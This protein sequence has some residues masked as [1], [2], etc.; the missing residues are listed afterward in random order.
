MGGDGIVTVHEKL[1]ELKRQKTAHTTEEL[2]R[3]G[4]KRYGELQDELELQHHGDYVMIEV[5]SGEH[6]VGQTPQEARR[7][8]EAAHPGRAFCLIRVGYKAVHKLK[9]R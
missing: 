2:D 1:E 4:W 3:L 5:D 9:P 6:F 8:A 7:L